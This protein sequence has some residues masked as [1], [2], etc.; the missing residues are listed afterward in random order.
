MDRI[1]GRWDLSEMGIKFPIDDELHGLIDEMLDVFISNQPLLS[2]PIWYIKKG[3]TERLLDGRLS[4]EQAALLH[5]K[6]VLEAS[7]WVL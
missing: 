5:K 1:N 4:E 7:T 6:F 3:I 2:V